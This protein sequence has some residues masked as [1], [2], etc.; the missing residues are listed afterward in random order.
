MINN[1]P[2]SKLDETI[3]NTLNNY[4]A[5]YDASDWSR[6][7][8]MLDAAPKS[9]SFKWSH[10]I[11]VIAG[12][13]VIGGAYLAYNAIS[14]SKNNDTEVS[15]SPVPE[16][17]VKESPVTVTKPAMITPAPKKEEPAVV[18]EEKT[19]VP[20]VK[21]ETAVLKPETKVISKE[22]KKKE[23]KKTEKITDVRP[24]IESN[25]RILGMGNEPIFGD[26]L[27]SSKGIVGETKEKE[28]TKKAAKA[29]KDTPVGWNQ[30]MLPN[31]NTDS[32]KK[33]REKRDSLKSE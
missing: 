13:V 6:M 11:T 32:L 27:D 10:A 16:N 2:D 5:Q 23:K 33:H 29:K 9:T 1:T 14:S 17:T 12:V 24:I 19:N 31:V 18:V 3:K 20:A 26:M 25:D 15:T 4:E 8:S 28:E 7:E 21:E 22:E 30:F